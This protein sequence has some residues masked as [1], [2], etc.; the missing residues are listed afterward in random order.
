MDAVVCISSN[1]LQI[2]VNLEGIQAYEWLERIVL[3]GDFFAWS[4]SYLMEIIKLCVNFDFDY[5]AS[6]HVPSVAEFT[7]VVTCFE[8]PFPALYFAFWTVL[9]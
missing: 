3:F 9:M 6:E 4:A 5:V 8:L 1:P 7:D 2:A